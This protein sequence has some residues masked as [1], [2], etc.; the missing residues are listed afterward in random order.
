MAGEWGTQDWGTFP[1]GGFSVSNATEQP[2]SVVYFLDI[3]TRVSGHLRFANRDIFIFPAPSWKE[4]AISMGAT[5]CW[6]LNEGSGVTVADSGINNIPLTATSAIVRGAP[7]PLAPLWDLNVA[8]TFPGGGGVDGASGSPSG[9]ANPGRNSFSVEC[10]FNVAAVPVTGHGHTFAYRNSG[11]NIIALQMTDD[12]VIEFRLDVGG[13]IVADIM[14]L[15]AAFLAD[16]NWHHL[17]GVR[18]VSIAQAIIYA[19]GKQLASGNEATPIGNLN[20]GG[21]SVFVGSGDGVNSTMAG[22]LFG[23]SWYERALTAGEVWE[24]YVEG[25]Q[26]PTGLRQPPEFRAL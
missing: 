16:G 12:P 25:V 20:V 19:D 8:A 9:K 24:N 15:N 6:M 3:Y 18:D 2:D 14:S 11:T 4:Q 26:G 7:G 1:W 10:W 13:V 17:V 21:A 22:N 5:S 23:V